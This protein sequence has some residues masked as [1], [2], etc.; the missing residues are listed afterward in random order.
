MMVDAH[1]HFWR[2]DRGDYGWLSGL[3]KINRDYLPA[4]LAPL[5]RNA[6]IDR[7]VLVQCAETVD[8]T[9]FMLGLAE[10]APFVAGVVGWVDF[11][12][13]DAARQIA[14]LAKNAKLV[15]L[16]PMLQDMEDKAWILREEVSPALAAMAAHGLR[17]DLL[18]KPPHL[19]HIPA[20][21]ERYQNLPMV[22]DHCAKPYI[23]RGEIAPWREQ[24]AAIARLPNVHCKLSGLI[25]EAGDWWNVPKLMPYV[26]AVIE[27]F[28][29]TRIMWGSDWPVCL[30][31]GEYAAWRTA[32]LDLTAHLSARDRDE[33]FGGAAARFYGLTDA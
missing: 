32:A 10:D 20:L 6:G 21:A 15:G 22:V 3:P 18:I 16:R 11:A 8:E 19:P 2:I 25:T 28:G 33:I 1:Q 12:A 23:A 14:D 24:M 30:L 9:H 4:D 29:P 13:P 17:L 31:A 26:E 7:T 5:L 27:L